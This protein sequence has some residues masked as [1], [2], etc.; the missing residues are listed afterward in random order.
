MPDVIDSNSLILSHENGAI[1]GM[2]RNRTTK[3]QSLFLAG[4]QY[5]MSVIEL[6]VPDITDYR[7]QFLDSLI[8]TK[9]AQSAEYHATEQGMPSASTRAAICSN[10]SRGILR[11][12]WQGVSRSSE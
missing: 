3:S 8:Y 7:F 6:F 12:V 4:R 11:R 5:E 2:S 1:R 9:K 10:P